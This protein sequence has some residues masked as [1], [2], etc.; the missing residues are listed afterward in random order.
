MI[1]FQQ[2][3]Q[4]MRPHNSFVRSQCQIRDS[5]K[6][7]NQTQSQDSSRSIQYGRF[8]FVLALQT[9]FA[10]GSSVWGQE[11]STNSIIRSAE[12]FIESKKPAPILERVKQGE[13]PYSEIYDQIKLGSNNLRILRPLTHE[14]M[15]EKDFG[16]LSNSIARPLRIGTV[17]TF[18]PALI[19]LEF[20]RTF[21]LS[22]GVVSIMAIVATSSLMTRLRLADIN[23]PLGARLFVYSAKNPDYVYTLTNEHQATSKEEFWTP[24]VEGDKV[25]IEYFVPHG[26]STDERPPFLVSAVSHMF[27]DPLDSPAEGSCHNNI[28][29]EWNTTA[30]AVGGV[31]FILGPDELWCTGSLL[32]NQSGDLMPFFLTAEH[33]GINNSNAQSV[34]V[35]WFYDGAGQTLSSKPYSDQAKW[36]ASRN[37]MEGSDFTLLQILGSLPSSMTWSGWTTAMPSLFTAV[38]GIHHPDGAYKRISYGDVATSFGCPNTYI[39]CANFLPVDWDNVGGGVTEPGSSGSGLWL[40]NSSDPK[41]VGQLWGGNS[42]CLNPVSNDFYGR[43][44]LTYNN[45]SSFMNGTWEGFDDSLEQNDTRSNPRELAPNSNNENLVVK[46]SDEDWYRITVPAGGRIT[47]SA[48]F[49]HDYGDVDLFLYRADD[50]NTID[51]SEST[52]DSEVVEHINTGGTADYFVRVYL[53]RGAVYSSTRNTYNANVGLQGGSNCTYSLSPTSQIFIASASTGSFIVTTQANCPWTAVSNHGWLSTSSS[54]I[55]DGQVNYAVAANSGNSRNGTIKVGMATFSVFQSA[56]NGSGCPVVSIVPG[57]TINTILTTG[58]VFTGTSRYVNEY[59]FIGTAGQQIAIAMNSVE[60]DTFLFLNNPSNQTIAQDDDGGGG[61]NSRI[62]AFNGFFILPATGTYRIYATSYSPDGQTG[63]T[64]TYSI[65]LSAPPAANDQFA[66]AQNLGGSSTLVEGTNVGASKETGEPNHAGNAGGASVWYRWSP[67]T[68]GQVTI[69]TGLSSFDTLLAVYTGS[70]VSSLTLVASNDDDGGLQSRVIFNAIAGMTYLIA[71]DGYQSGSNPP[72]MGIISLTVNLLVTPTPNPTATPTST[73]T[74]TPT[75]TPTATPTVTPTPGNRPARFDYDGDQK[76]DI[77]VWRPTNGGWYLNRSTAGFIGISFGLS[78]D[79]IA[80]ADY[81]GDGKTD[82]ALFRP[83]EG[84]W[85]FLKSTTNTYSGLV[86]GANGDIPAPGDF[87]GDGLADVAI[88]R[89]STGHFWLAQ[90]TAGVTVIPFGTSGD[91][92]VIGDYDSDG[93]DDVAIYRPSNG[94]WWINRST[95]GVTAVTF[96]IPGDKVS[97][98]DYDGDGRTDISVYRPSTSAWY[99]INSSTLIP[100][101][102]FF[103]TTGDIPAPGDYDGDGRADQAIFRPSNGQWWLNRSSAGVYATNFGLNGDIPTPNAFGN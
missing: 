68:S 53:Y 59:N 39:Q 28:P 48:N 44:D 29:T 67:S 13:R 34:R 8:V 58:C 30:R 50:A 57:Q 74:A 24:P 19:P 1:D 80:P 2:Q 88:F 73:P 42:S 33:C 17:R 101:G 90:T 7:Q 82:P 71:V 5:M 78:T 64:G 72:A 81:D 14:E 87:D 11:L 47:F 20:S 63:S 62:P 46:Y 6:V 79:K 45:I 56:G 97:H 25:I 37:G 70:T 27:R 49:E 15:E 69:H 22:D 26:F 85:Y 40:D 95:G 76:A 103:G 92:P 77:S 41:L 55:G 93:R 21:S 31:D 96:G 100:T 61:T 60:F 35:W 94:Q 16:I 38:V 75:N 23:L 89:P 91:V 36:L 83:S 86:F 9:L 12:H 10:A 51:T 43:F 66:D 4:Q 102:M 54:G 84:G 98:A 32:T 52:S 99:W 65:S 18:S 3:L